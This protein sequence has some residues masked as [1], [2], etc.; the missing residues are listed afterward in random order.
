MRNQT[1][2]KSAFIM[3]SIHQSREDPIDQKNKSTHSRLIQHCLFAKSCYRLGTIPCTTPS[4]ELELRIQEPCCKMWQR[5]RNESRLYQ[6]DI[7]LGHV[8]VFLVTHKKSEFYWFW[9]ASTSISIS[10]GPTSGP[11]VYWFKFLRIESR[12]KEALASWIALF[13]LL[14]QLDWDFWRP[15]QIRVAICC[16]C[17]RIGIVWDQFN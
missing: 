17:N 2:Q 6:L 15:I 8:L 4:V 7:N 13:K 5:V 3:E 14:T 9:R 12:V 11:I 1:R 10:I 16:S